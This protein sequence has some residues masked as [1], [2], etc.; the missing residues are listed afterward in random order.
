MIAILFVYKGLQLHIKVLRKYDSIALSNR[1]QA[2][3]FMF[4]DLGSPKRYP[5]A[6]GRKG[7]GVPPHQAG[8]GP[9][10]RVG[11]SN[12]HFAFRE[13]VRT[14]FRIEPLN[15]GYELA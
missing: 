5:P 6:F 15:S 4:C 14:I 1:R 7:G 10:I 8:R 2:P 3:L 11:R 12:T 13:G 9:A